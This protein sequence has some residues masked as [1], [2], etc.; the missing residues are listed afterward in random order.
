MV[1]FMIPNQQIYKLKYSILIIYGILLRIV[2]T[3]V[4]LIFEV[5]CLANNKL[6]LDKSFF[7]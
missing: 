3:E 7:G 2:H 1:G 5:K 6:M 4:Q